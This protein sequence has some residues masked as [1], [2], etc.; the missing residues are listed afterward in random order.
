MGLEVEIAALKTDADAWD[1]AG[2]DLD[3]PTSAIADLTLDG[4]NDVTGMG[5]RMGIDA[6]YETLRG[7]ME[8]LMTQ[9]KEY[10]G[11]LADGLI[12]IADYYEKQESATSNNM[13]SVEDDVEGN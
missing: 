6:T 2:T 11:E 1:Q 12:S 4:A 5:E 8:S 7:N 9:A 13:S 10:F 3:G